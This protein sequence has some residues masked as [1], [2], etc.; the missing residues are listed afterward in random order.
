M[1]MYMCGVIAVQGAVRVLSVRAVS[2]DTWILKGRQTFVRSNGLVLSA[3][4]CQSLGPGSM[5]QTEVCLS[6]VT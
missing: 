3:L 2:H 5:R 1:Y 6:F 4:A